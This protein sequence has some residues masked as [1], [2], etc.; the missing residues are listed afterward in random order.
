MTPPSTPPDVPP[1]ADAVKV[2]AWQDIGQ[3]HAYRDFEAASWYIADDQGQLEVVVVGHQLADGRVEKLSVHVFRASAIAIS[4]LTGAKAL[5]LAH[6]L[7]QASAR[8]ADL[9]EGDR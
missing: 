4:G 8:I 3:P 6:C 5:E 2:Y 1:P 9:E 7:I